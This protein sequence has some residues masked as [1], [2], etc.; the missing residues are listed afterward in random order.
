MW[1]LFALIVSI[2][3]A[4]TYGNIFSDSYAHSQLMVIPPGSLLGGPSE[5]CIHLPHTYFYTGSVFLPRIYSTIKSEVRFMTIGGGV[6][7]VEH[8]FYDDKLV[9]VDAGHTDYAP[10]ERKDRTSENSIRL[11][12]DPVQEHADLIKGHEDVMG[13]NAPEVVSKICAYNH[14]LVEKKLN[15]MVI[16]VYDDFSIDP[17][18]AAQILPTS[19]LL[20]FLSGYTNYVTRELMDAEPN[21]PMT[22]EEMSA[23]VYQSLLKTELSDEV[24][25]RV[26]E[27]AEKVGRTGSLYWSME[28]HTNVI[29]GKLQDMFLLM[30]VIRHNEDR[31][32]VFAEKIETHVYQLSY[33]IV[34]IVLLL[35][36]IVKV[37]MIKRTLVR[38]LTK[39]EYDTIMAYEF[40]SRTT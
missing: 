33:A 26:Q 7:D 28:P 29:G 8:S 10:R 11:E 13:N 22:F 18:L 19:E 34:A 9:T 15:V 21:N 31:R 24:Q 25:L 3:G 2:N 35:W 20:Q 1:P 16:T 30:E 4:T 38:A 17:K 12:L 37:A 6:V 36:S 39:R 14:D 23:H 27:E 40:T 32:Q 5:S